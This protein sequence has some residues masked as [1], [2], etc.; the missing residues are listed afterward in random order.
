[1]TRP[2][3]PDSMAS[4]LEPA[5]DFANATE[6]QPNWEELGRIELEGKRLKREG[7]LTPA[8]LQRLI[9]EAAEFVPEERDD[10]ISDR[11]GAIQS[12]KL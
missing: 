3:E 10:V 7:K 11:V 9:D 6:A 1:M 12:T 4:D 5:A 2:S 8:E